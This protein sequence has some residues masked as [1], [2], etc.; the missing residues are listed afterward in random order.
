MDLEDS[1]R[2]DKDVQCPYCNFQYH[3][4]VEE[5]RIRQ[6]KYNWELY[7]RIYS[8]FTS[9]K[10]RSTHLKVAGVSLLV[11]LAL[12]SLGMISMFVVDSFTLQHKGVALAGGLF[13]I[14]VFLGVINSFK[15]ESFVLSLTGTMFS[16]LNAGVWGYLNSVGGFLLISKEF[17]IPYTFIVLV[18]SLLAMVLIVR[19]KRLFK[20]GY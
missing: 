10:D 9:S 19:N 8:Q 1:D 6:V 4:K 18:F 14:F 11:T 7:D 2:E 5:T 20:S 13:S 12:F 17:S 15:K 3:D 16:T